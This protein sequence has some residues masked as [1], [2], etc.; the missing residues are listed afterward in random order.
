MLKVQ[1]III[2]AFFSIIVSLYTH[3]VIVYNTT[4]REML[5]SDPKDST[6]PFWAQLNSFLW[7]YG[8]FI[9]AGLFIVSLFFRFNKPEVVRMTIICCLFLL[10]NYTDPFGIVNWILD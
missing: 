10:L 2:I 5:L 6:M 3:A 1:R 9:L 8:S 4:G 7:V